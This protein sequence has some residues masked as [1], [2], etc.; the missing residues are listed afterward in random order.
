MRRREF[1]ASVAGVVAWPVVARAQQPAMPVIGYLHPQSADD[2]TNYTV[3]F[4]QGLKE[5][6]Y[7]VGQN[8]AVEYRWAENQY[9]SN[10]KDNLRFLAAQCLR[11]RQ[12]D[13]RPIGWAKGCSAG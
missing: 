1:I 13:D 4:L 6:G 2:F 10:A 5:I 8:V 12:G 7:V 3:A 9:S 11:P